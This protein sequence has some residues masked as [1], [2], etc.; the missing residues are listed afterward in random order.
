MKT[1]WTQEESDAYWNKLETEAPRWWIRAE[2]LRLRELLESHVGLA[3]ETGTEPARI[4]RMLK[5]V[6]ASVLDTR[7]DRRCPNPDA[8]EAE[9]LRLVGEYQQQL[10]EEPIDSRRLHSI[11]AQLYAVDHQ[12]DQAQRQRGKTN[13]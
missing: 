11:E 8:L 2:L 4:V 7:E 10:R 12:L 5:R 9:R 13:V 1:N 6:R 3:L